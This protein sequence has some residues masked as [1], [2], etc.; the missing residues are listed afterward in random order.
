MPIRCWSEWEVRRLSG[1]A[2]AHIRAMKLLFPGTRGEIDVRSRLHRMHSCLLLD[3]RILIDC[4]ADWL[5]K[6]ERLG[7]EAIVLTHAHPDHIGGLKRGASCV[8]FATSETWD[9][10]KHYPIAER[11][12]ILPGKPFSIAGCVFEAFTVE[13]SLIAPAVGYR[14]SKAGVSIFYV[15][16]LVSIHERH[17][18]L[19][20][21]A[22]Y[23]G[24][25]ASISRPL[26]RRRNSTT[27]GH[28]S[29]RE[30][31]GWCRDE[32]IRNVV[33][34]HCGSQIV[35]ID[36]R[37][38]DTTV[39]RMQSEFGVELMIAIDGLELTVNGVEQR[40]LAK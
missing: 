6:F 21:I 39:E 40:A 19:S 13:H 17:A 18:A 3:G 8:V 25:G 14:I 31:L 35:K 11:A 1:D 26:I 7:P 2:D 9:R 22:F 5:G 24:D 16:D 4:G 38:L 30:Q 10:L 12:T 32:G 23:I 34:T 33:I 36:H 29:V 37:V 20:G 28:A 27:I 15:P